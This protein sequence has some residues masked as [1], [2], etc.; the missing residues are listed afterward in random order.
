MTGKPIAGRKVRLWSDN[1][2]NLVGTTDAE[3]RTVPRVHSRPETLYIDLL[4][5]DE[6]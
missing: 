5:D 3:G 4:R 2:W 1:G 6:A